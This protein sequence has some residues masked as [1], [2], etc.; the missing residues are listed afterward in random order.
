M[1]PCCVSTST[2]SSTTSCGFDCT[3]VEC[4]SCTLRDP[5]VQPAAFFRRSVIEPDEPVLRV[6]LHRFLDYELWLRLHSRGV[7][8]VHAPRSDRATGRLLSALGDRAG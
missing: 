8:F 4:A 2:G 1:S 6:D 5:I 3:A 7:R